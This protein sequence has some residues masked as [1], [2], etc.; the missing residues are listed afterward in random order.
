MMMMMMIRT[1]MMTMMMMMMMMRCDVTMYPFDPHLDDCYS[2]SLHRLSIRLYIQ[3][4]I[5]LHMYHAI[6]TTN[7]LLLHFSPSCPLYVSLIHFFLVHP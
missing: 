2:Y 5:P 7:I 6:H 3:T 1:M 4:N